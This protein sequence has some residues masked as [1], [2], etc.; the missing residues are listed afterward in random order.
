MSKKIATIIETYTESDDK[1]TIEKSKQ[2]YV[3]QLVAGEA[4]VVYLWVKY[5]SYD[6][7]FGVPAKSSAK[8]QREYGFFQFRKK[9]ADGKFTMWSIYLDQAELEEMK[10]GFA[11]L[12][13]V[14][15]SQRKGNWEKYEREK[16]R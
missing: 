3:F 7:I 12:F 14:S 8:Y 9:L 13:M 6:F 15:N 16:K 11:K 1:P 2:P 4:I 10:N 5:P